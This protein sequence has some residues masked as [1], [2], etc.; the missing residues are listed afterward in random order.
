[1]IVGI[2][3]AGRGCWAGPLVAAAVMLSEPIPGLMDSKQLSKKQREGLELLIREQAMAYGIGWVWPEQLDALGLTAA[4]TQAMAEALAQ[5]EADHDEV[6]IDGNLNYLPTNPL[7]RVVV[8]ADSLIP[9]VS[10]ASILAKV[11]RDRYMTEIA[12]DYPGYDF[13]KHVGYGTAAHVQ[14]LQELGVSKI[15]RLSYKPVKKFLVVKP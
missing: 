11:A 10:A 13:E 12:A 1:M 4:T 5:I 15:H 8:K 9:E 6:I 2:D 14:R 7:V 3:E